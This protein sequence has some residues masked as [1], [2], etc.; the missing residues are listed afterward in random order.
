MRRIARHKRAAG[1]RRQDEAR[2]TRT[3]EMHGPC[4]ADSVFDGHDAPRPFGAEPEGATRRPRLRTRLVHAVERPPA[5]RLVVRE[6]SPERQATFR[7]ARSACMDIGARQREFISRPLLDETAAGAR[8]ARMEHRTRFSRQPVSHRERAR[9]EN[10]STVVSP[11][12]A[13]VQA[14]V[15]ASSRQCGKE[16]VAGETHTGVAVQVNCRAKGQ[17]ETA[18]DVVLRRKRGLPCTAIVHIEVLKHITAGQRRT[19]AKQGTAPVHHNRL[20]P[21]HQ[22]VLD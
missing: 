11:D 19:S 20:E 16:L 10:V 3:V 18:H 15:C 14:A 8:K 17:L 4:P 7:H 21:R 5:D 1:S 13:D 9:G 22:R 2:P 6:A 12:A